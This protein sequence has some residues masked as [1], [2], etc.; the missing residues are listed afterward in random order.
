MSTNKNRINIVNKKARFEYQL[1]DKYVAGIQLGGTEIKSIR[2]GKASILEAFCVIEEGEVYLRNMHIAEYGN[3]SFYQHKPKA[4][5]K[6]L[7]NRQEINK[8]DKKMKAKGFTIVPLRI[9]INNKG[10]AKVE[11]ALAQGKKLYDKRQDLKE[12]DD[13]RA[14]DRIKKAY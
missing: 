1:L 2:Q 11:I 7:L 9:F 3:A 13:K 6:L 4:D 10:L 8:L 14:M 12:K 5:R